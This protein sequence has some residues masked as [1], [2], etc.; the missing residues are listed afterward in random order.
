MLTGAN[1]EA[2]ILWNSQKIEKMLKPLS[3]SQSLLF[4]TD[5]SYYRFLDRIHEVEPTLRSQGLWE[6]P[7]P[8]LN[9]FIPS[10]SIVK[11]DA[12]VFKSLITEAFSG[13]ILIYP[14]NRNK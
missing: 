4:A 6:V 9:L 13:P 10:S 2:P 3:F 11:F 8:W 1:N 12:L 7:H 5:V 14:L